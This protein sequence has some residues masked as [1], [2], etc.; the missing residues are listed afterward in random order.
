MKELKNHIE[1]I[2]QLCN[3]H[4]VKTLFAFGSV[5]SDKFKTES[6]IDLVVDID[7]NDP[8]DYSDNY[9]ALKF[10]LE[11][12]LNRSI[13]LLEDKAIKNPF[14]KKQIDNTKVLIYGR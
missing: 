3:A 5:L 12:I 4:H 2:K 8:F 13:D 14:L 1:Q 9:F 7:S 11:N 6:D 10:Q